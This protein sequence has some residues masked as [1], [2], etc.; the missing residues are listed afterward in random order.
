MVIAITTADLTL[1][2]PETL[3]THEEEC[4]CNL[5]A[6]M[7]FNKPFLD[8]KYIKIE[9]ISCYEQRFLIGSILG[10]VILSF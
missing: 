3:R 1:K 2:I 4:K 8:W 5:D 6:L 7:I 10:V 9:F